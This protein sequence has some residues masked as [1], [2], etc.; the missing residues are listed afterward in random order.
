MTYVHL[1]TAGGDPHPG[2]PAT[3]GR[4][5]DPRQLTC[6]ECLSLTLSQ[7]GA[8]PV[9]PEPKGISGSK[10]ALIIVAVVLGL[11][12][13]LSLT[14]VLVGGGDENRAA[15]VAAAPEPTYSVPDPVLP[16]GA[17]DPTPEPKPT[18][19]T[20][21]TIEDGVYHVG[22]DIAAGTYRL[23]EPVTNSDLCYWRKSKD[24]E[25]ENI[26]DNDLAGVGRL[27]VTLKRGQWFETNRC[28]TWVKK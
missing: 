7:R 28:G 20:K 15:R 14:A 18:K 9:T 2:V 10:V 23:A 6:P 17:E 27:Q 21:P 13:I 3:A 22:E 11:C 5:A 24:A 8:G 1:N 25:G 4:T 26:I 16:P 12:G 19:P